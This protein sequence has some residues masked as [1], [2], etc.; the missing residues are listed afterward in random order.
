[1]ERSSKIHAGRAVPP[2]TGPRQRRLTVPRQG[3]VPRFLRSRPWTQ[4]K[5]LMGLP[6][7]WGVRSP[8]LHQR[9]SVEGEAKLVLVVTRIR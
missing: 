5:P 8:W 6:S 3:E 7:P 9:A 4:I 2:I 1:V